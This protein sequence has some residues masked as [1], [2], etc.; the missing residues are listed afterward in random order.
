[1]TTATTSASTTEM[2]QKRTI[3]RG[4][5]ES[6]PATLTTS[7][8]L[9]MSYPR[10]GN[11]RTSVPGLNLPRTSRLSLGTAA[12]IARWPGRA[13]SSRLGRVRTRPSGHLTVTATA[14]ALGLRTSAFCTTP[15]PRRSSSLSSTWTP[16]RNSAMASR[17]FLGS[18]AAKMERC[19]STGSS[20]SAGSSSSMGSY[21]PSHRTLTSTVGFGRPK[22]RPTSP[23]RRSQQGAQSR[24]ASSRSRQVLSFL[25]REQV[26][27]WGFVYL[28]PFTTPRAPFGAPRKM[29]RVPGLN[30]SMAA[31]SS[32]G[33]AANMCR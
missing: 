6:W 17:R 31:L 7:P 20:F 25:R 14:S 10:L 33:A 15:T 3:T 1:M 23:M 12:N 9:R 19:L 27:G 2:I 30:R 5:G 29:T 11:G 16:G 22:Q 24:S 13:L 4:S 28:T 8:Q 18:E 32:L 26:G 21:R